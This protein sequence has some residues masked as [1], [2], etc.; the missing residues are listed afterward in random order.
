MIMG[1]RLILEQ[2]ASRHK[3]EGPLLKAEILGSAKKP[4]ACRG[5][6]F[7]QDEKTESRS[8]RHFG[9]QFTVA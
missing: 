3:A 8:A 1:K 2:T 9:G 6:F 5:F 7:V 4:R